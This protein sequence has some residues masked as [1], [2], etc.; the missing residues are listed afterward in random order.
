MAGRNSRVLYNMPDRI[1]EVRKSRHMTQT[2]LGNAMGSDKSAVSRLE[3]GVK[4][5]NL[6]T[7][8]NVADALDVPIATFFVE[9]KEQD[10][11]EDPFMEAFRERTK[12]IP[13]EKR[14]AFESLI[15]AAFAM[16]GV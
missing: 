15:E 5:P 2:D 16:A 12:G 9:E 14:A 4:L 10:L 8:K 3:N 13:P 11:A 1:K 6:T 7:L